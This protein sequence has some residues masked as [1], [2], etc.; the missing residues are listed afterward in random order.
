MRG[1]SGP[2]PS[3]VKQVLF[4][5]GSKCGSQIWALNLFSPVAVGFGV[6]GK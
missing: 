5:I 2:V 3:L 6:I 1:D 4:L